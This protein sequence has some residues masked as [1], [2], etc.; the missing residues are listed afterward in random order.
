MTP[1]DTGEL[2]YTLTS[3]Q[4]QNL[5]IMGRSAIELLSLVPGAAD[6]GK[7]NVDTYS[8]Q[9]AGFTPN[10]SAYSVNGNRFDLTQIVSDGTPA[11]R[12]TPPELVP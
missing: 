9:V 7:L 11:P 12:A 2:S 8:G 10:A 1:A 5:N 4:V 6:S 3:K